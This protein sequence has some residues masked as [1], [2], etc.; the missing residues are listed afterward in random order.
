[1]TP[2]LTVTDVHH[3]YGDVPVLH[4]VTLT[5]PEGGLTAVVGR[6]GC[7]KTTLLRVVAGFERAR[8]GIV[9]IGGREVAGADQDVA[10]ED[11]RI[12]YVTQDG[13]LFPHLTVA[14]NITF[15][16]PRRERR[17]GHRVAEL[18]GLLGM[19][20]SYGGRRPHELSGGQ[21]QR[22]ALA[23]ALAPRPDLVLLDE[24]FSAL[25]PE[26]RAT[27]RRAALDAVAAT[28]ATAVLVTHDQAEALSVADR[29]AVMRDGA[30]VQ[31]GTP[32]E[33]YRHPADA[34]VA[35][36]L[37]EVVALPA[38]VEAGR[39]ATALGNVPTGEAD[40]RTTVLVR[41]EQIELVAGAPGAVVAEVVDVD[42]RGHDTLV[43][44]RLPDGT[45]VRARCAGHLAPSVAQRVGV[46]VNGAALL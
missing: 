19:D 32:V 2:G 35:T 33:L 30:I 12:G 11:R 20:P 24:P 44:A 15:G 8:A 16:L 27:T 34:G 17:A 18:L 5:V 23:R 9:E 38:C 10:P 46:V 25:D 3:A 45:V 21:Q 42:F 36:F 7:G 31:E 14:R 28:G 6:S 40:G 13:N 4:G 37:G 1:M 41:P 26:L 39:A 29:V 43:G 22:V